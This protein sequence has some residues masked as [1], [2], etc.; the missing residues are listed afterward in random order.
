MNNSEIEI[1][2]LKLRQQI[3]S[4]DNLSSLELVEIAV[5]GKKGKFNDWLTSLKEAT[6]PAEKKLL[7]IFFN[8]L[9][10]RLLEM[11]TARKQELIAAKQTKAVDVTIPGLDL[12]LGS[13][14]PIT[15]TINEVA[16]IF[17]KIGFYRVSYPE[18]E[19]EF[20]SFDSLNMP[21]THPA[22]DEFES[23]T[24]NGEA[25]PEYG[26]MVLSPHT[27]S[28]QVREMFRLQKPPIRMINIARC[29][30]RNSDITHTPMFH[31]FEGLC[32]DKNI[33]IKHL[34]GAIAHFA[35]EFF[36]YDVEI[37][38][39][40]YHFQFTEPSFEVDTTCTICRGTLKVNGEKCR[41]CK[42]GWLELGGA[43]MVHENVLKAG[44][45]DPREFSGWAFG[46]GVERI[47]MMKYQLD[48]LRKLYSGELSYFKN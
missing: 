25:S 48:D 46:F 47:Y 26:K 16:E 1:E 22:R 31:Q 14:H 44:K 19:Y 8:G 35:K 43:G 9:K 4:A 11:F 32:V 27:S 18:I 40:P 34:K 5:F 45:I 37:R 24:V 10:P 2:V 29:F 21:S 7:G 3:A 23:F 36:G 38:L 33:S 28:G 39:R 41:I 20:F 42:G 12:P 15:Q 6:D 30:R 13:L 17:R